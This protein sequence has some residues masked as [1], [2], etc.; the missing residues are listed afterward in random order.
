MACVV[1]SV[2]DCRLFHGQNRTSNHSM[3][4]WS[5]LTDE[6]TDT[7]SQHIDQS[8][9]IRIWS[10]FFLTFVSLVGCLAFVWLIKDLIFPWAARPLGRTRRRPITK[11]TGTEWKKMET[12]HWRAVFDWNAMPVRLSQMY[13]CIFIWTTLIAIIIGIRCVSSTMLGL[14]KPKIVNE[15]TNYKHLNRRSRIARRIKHS[16]RASSTV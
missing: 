13:V 12:K 14:V 16:H 7:H 2:V 5:R 4:H 8:I 1:N 10:V 9:Y 3:A 15:V 6:R 11:I